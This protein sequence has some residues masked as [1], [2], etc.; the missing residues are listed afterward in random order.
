MDSFLI[1]LSLVGYCLLA[2]GYFWAIREAKR[3]NDRANK[4][5]EIAEISAR[6][7][8]DTYKFARELT[9][10]NRAVLTAE[11]KEAWDASFSQLLH[12]LSSEQT[13]PVPETKNGTNHNL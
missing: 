3:S 4:W 5:R 2:I 13:Q 9:T 6:L 10:S 1:I 12:L 7:S 8:V 11:R